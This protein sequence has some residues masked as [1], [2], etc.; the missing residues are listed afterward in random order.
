MR[1]QYSCIDFIELPPANDN[2][3][4]A[5]L[6]G[7]HRRLA[8]AV[9][10]RIPPE[11]MLPDDLLLEAKAAGVQNPEAHLERL[12][13]G[14]VGGQRGIFEDHLSKYV[15]GMFGKWR[16]WEETDRAKAS[17]VDSTRVNPGL[18]VTPAERVA[19]LPR[20]VRKSTAERCAQEGRDVRMLALNFART[21]HIN[22]KNLDVNLAAQAFEQYL[23]RVRKEAA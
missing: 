3:L 20:W 18:T 10:H 17:G 1:H 23:E 22:P 12:K 11:W 4:P 19:G 16:T 6:P 9:I 2:H 5:P 15:R 7:A 13:A 14:P 8:P 21:H